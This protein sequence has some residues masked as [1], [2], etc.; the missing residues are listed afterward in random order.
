MG[1]NYNFTSTAKQ[2]VLVTIACITPLALL[3]IYSQYTNRFHLR[4]RAWAIPSQLLGKSKLPS[5]HLPNM[6]QK[7]ISPWVESSLNTYVRTPITFR[8]DAYGTILPSSM[9]NVLKT[10]KPY[11]LFC[12]GSTTEGWATP[13]GRRVPDQFTNISGYLSV[14]A[15][16]SGKDLVGCL[17]TLQG[18]FNSVKTP[19][20]KI[21]ISTSVN[22]LM[23]FGVTMR[24]NK[25]PI[26]NTTENEQTSPPGQSLKEIS[27]NTIP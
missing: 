14:N 21:V 4:S 17:G 18:V 13:E 16:K 9:E 27:Q 15:A 24:K 2:A 19:P 3:E 12:G 8:T 20:A 1:K 10:Q 5:T 23:R 11:V 25:R 26:K 6:H 22:T 7:E